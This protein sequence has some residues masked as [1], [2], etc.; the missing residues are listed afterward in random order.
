MYTLFFIIVRIIRKP[1][2]SILFE[3]YFSSR[4]ATFYYRCLR[5]RSRHLYADSY[6]LMEITKGL[7]LAWK[8]GL[9][10]SVTFIIRAKIDLFLIFLRVS[11]YVLLRFVLKGLY[12]RMVDRVTF[13]L[14]NETVRNVLNLALSKCLSTYLIVIYRAAFWSSV[15]RIIYVMFDSLPTIYR[16]A[17]NGR[18][19]RPIKIE[20]SSWKLYIK[21]EWNN[22]NQRNTGFI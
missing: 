2:K 19:K 22:C 3:F 18:Q 20:A 10:C 9:P 4:N 13:S 11:W 21:I 8:S 12:D 16:I 1:V 14:I 6:F 5:Q 15:P 17:L 7:E